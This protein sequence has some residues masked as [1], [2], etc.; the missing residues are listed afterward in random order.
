[1]GTRGKKALKQAIGGVTG[2]VGFTEIQ[3]AFLTK[4]DGTGTLLVN[5]GVD[6][7]VWCHRRTEDGRIR[8]QIIVWYPITIM[9]TP[10]RDGDK[11]LEDFR[12]RIGKPPGIDE[13]FIIDANT[14]DGLSSS[15]SA[16]PMEDY[17]NQAYWTSLDQITTLRATPTDPPT[18]E[19]TVQGTLWYLDS[20]NVLS[21][22]TTRNTSVITA[23]I[24][25]L[26]GTGKHQ[27]GLVYLNKTT[28]ALAL[29]TTT[30]VSPTGA[31][32][33]KSEFSAD[34]DG[35]A[36][37]LDSS[38]LPIMFVNLYDGQTALRE[39]STRDDLYRAWGDPRPLFSGGGGVGLDTFDRI[40]VSRTSGEVVTS[41]TAGNVLLRR[42]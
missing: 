13:F 16:T 1:M 2:A 37:S 30:A 31:L 18:K 6:R 32:P 35:A 26:S 25:A 9:L 17:I 14:L 33:A 8:D 29:A 22:F 24:A 5:S 23:A 34:I 4:G 41:R 3:S 21:R 15:G 40:L 7:R 19:L 12:V 11:S 42:M 10:L 36:F 28:H 39:D 20:A 38:Q 27:L